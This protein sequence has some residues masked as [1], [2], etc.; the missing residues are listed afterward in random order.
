MVNRIFL[1]LFCLAF[2]IVA[3]SEIR[4]KSIEKETL[5]A[6]PFIFNM[7]HFFSEKEYVVSFPVWFNDSVIRNQRIET[8]QR[9]TYMSSEEKDTSTASIKSIKTYHFNE[10]GLLQGLTVQNYY[11]N[12]PIGSTSFVLENHDENG[13]AE[14][15]SSPG[16]STLSDEEILER[17]RRYK[18][19][20]YTK[21]YLV[22]AEVETGRY[23]F[24]MLNERN[25]GTLSVDSILSPAEQDIVAFGDPFK[26]HKRYQV[27]NRV[28]EFNREEYE[29][30]E[31][32]NLLQISFDQYPFNYK[33]S[34][35]YNNK[36]RCTGY[37]DSTFSGEK[38]LTRK[39]SMFHFEDELPVRI[40]HENKS[41]KSEA[42][43]YQF[44]VF[45]Y[46]F[47]DD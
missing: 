36:G 6:E 30:D 14:V 32:G 22:Y 29:Y 28:N 2:V 40:I 17:Y 4:E 7:E 42:G 37:V 15:S 47:Y 20:E 33:R 1:S 38:Y 41:G 19:E 26:P 34:I 18:K 27:K 11:D 8:L 16:Q 43:Y 24:Y 35:L 23:L 31:A 10:E 9:I 45:K 12:L 46:S 44:E 3:C 25:W 21:K 39:E 5:T 13:F